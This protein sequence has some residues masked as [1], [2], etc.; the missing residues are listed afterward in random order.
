MPRRTVIV[1][2]GLGLFGAGAIALA[3]VPSAKSPKPVVP[4]GD[5]AHSSVSPAPQER[6]RTLLVFRGAE[7]SPSGGTALRAQLL[8]GRVP[9]G[10][11]VAVLLTNE[12]CAPDAQGISHCT[13]ALRLPNGSIF[14]VRHPHN[15]SA[16]P[17]LAPGERVLVSLAA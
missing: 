3:L 16:V 4:A 10:R 5:E 17:C 6:L 13:N 12:D 8:D 9:A 14:T 2:L 1:A 11:N 15:M 7:P